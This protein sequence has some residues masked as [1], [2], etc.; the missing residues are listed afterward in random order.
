MIKETDVA[1]LMKDLVAIPSPYFEEERIMDHVSGWFRDNGLRVN[2]REYH[3]SVV[4][5]F[6]GKNLLVQLD[7]GRPGPVI[8]LNAHLDTVQLC[9]G[10]TE[11]PFGARQDGDRIYGLGML[12]MKA[13]AAANMIALK[14]FAQS[15]PTFRGKVIASFVSVE[16]GPY[17]LGTNAL[18]EEGTLNG[19]DLSIVTEPS[20]GFTGEPFPV[21]C[22]G[23]RGGYGLEIEVLGRSSHAAFPREGMS[24]ALDAA[25]IVCELEHVAYVSDVHLGTGDACV[26]GIES[27]GGA[28]SV[29]DRAVIRLFWHIVVGE[30]PDTIAAEIH[31]AAERAAVRCKYEIRFREAPCE[32]A[33]GFMPY[34]VDPAHP[35]VR[36]FLDSAAEVCGCPPQEAYFKS[37]GDFNYLGTRLGA[38]VVIFGPEG[39]NFHGQDEYATVSSTVKTAETVLAF[40]KKELAAK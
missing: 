27:D 11:D 22:L 8:H 26:I 28:C 7:S 33:K 13:G 12:D 24:A 5:G 30:S 16:E 38:P 21:A 25:K 17:G 23:A 29:P 31:K 39:K 1:K 35:L 10:W 40:L 3:E 4:T 6:H 20:A 2:V 32:D 15:V 36:S 19:I 34:T 37:I 9:K 14:E 18:I